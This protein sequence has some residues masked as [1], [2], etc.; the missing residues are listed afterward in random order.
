M[1]LSRFIYSGVFTLLLPVILVR[2]W[3]RGKQLP[4]YRQR[5]K[6]RF[7]FFHAPV[8]ALNN[9]TD[10]TATSESSNKNSGKNNSKIIWIHTVSVGESI[11]A[12]PLIKLLISQ[13]N[14][15]IITCTT[16]TGS[17]QITN[18]FKDSVFH[19]YAPYDL[20][21]FI[22]RFLHKAKPDTAIFMETELWPNTLA[23]C[24]NKKINTLLINARL[25]EKSAKGYGRFNNLT[26]EILHNISYAAIQN[27]TDA[28]RFYALGL[29]KTKAKITGN[30]KFDITINPNT[31]QQAQ[32]IKQQYSLQHQRPIIIAAS[33]HK[34]E[35]DI[36]LNAFKRVL[37][38]HSN[39]LLLLVPRHP[40][41]FNDVY[42]LSQNNHFATVKR[43]DNP[44]IDNATQ[45]IIGD[46]MGELS[47]LYGA[48]DIAFV[49]GSL[50]ENG[51]HNYIE[52]AAWAVPIISG[53]SQ[54]N[55]L[56]IAREL[57]QSGALTT[58]DTPQTMAEHICDLLSDNK[59]REHAGQQG[60]QYIEKNTG[61]LGKTLEVLER[62][63]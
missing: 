9:Q 33:T 20:P 46:T 4:A 21:Y 60:L 45:V 51:G 58:I 39:A 1:A 18:T 5:I 11:A 55:F 26:R 40:D 61:A 43:S 22:N 16:P 14:R 53:P 49:G 15:V 24:A 37:N 27:T 3:L 10:N 38:T 52:P 12:T 44:T 28:E 48:A 42:Q 35:D 36:I 47:M 7:G 41:R 34:G 30:I 13:N 29:D 56:D 54:F 31:K 57:E 63:I 59:K 8:Y 17:K 50:V 23:C 25:S 19:V 2:L 32:H 62:F 6:E